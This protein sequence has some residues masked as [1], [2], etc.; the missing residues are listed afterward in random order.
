MALT[1]Y[2]ELQASVA[3]FLNRSDMT[4]VIPDFITMCEADMNRTLR[5]REMSIR[6]RAPIDSQYVKLPADFLG[7]RNIDL[8]TDPVTPLSYLNLQNLDI[9]RS[10]KSTGKP[11]YYSIM[12]GSIEFAPVPDSEYTLEIIYY[13]KIPAL[14]TNSTNWLLTDHPDAYLYGTLMHSAPYLQSDERVGLWAGKYNQILQQIKTSDESAKFSGSTP[15][16]SFTPFG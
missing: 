11:L 2:T 12:Q 13:Q 15:S 14:S 3:D 8:L 5:V 4:S 10:N 7:M 6:T 16:I 9:H 1:N